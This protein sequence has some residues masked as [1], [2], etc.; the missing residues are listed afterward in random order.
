MKD[1]LRLVLAILAI[2]LGIAGYWSQRP[3]GR[4]PGVLA[5]AEPEQTDP[6]LAP[7]RLGTALITPRANYDIIARVLSVDR[8]RVD[9]GSWLAPVDFA[10][11]WSKMSD[12]AVLKHFR[13][14]QGGR[15]FTIYPDDDAI[16]LHEAL[17]LASNMHLVPAT[18]RVRD[19]L[20]RTRVGNIA[21]LRGYLI[22]ANRDDGFSWHTSLTREDTGDGACELMWVEAVELR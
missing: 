10:V 18:L 20:L 5:A 3:I 1:G 15:F 22:D 4:A 2:V 7:F 14:T 16:D 13:V 6:T 9:G 19:Q 21:H 11:G 12:S 8:Y 17:R